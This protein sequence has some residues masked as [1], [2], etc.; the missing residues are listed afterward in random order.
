MSRS[1][2]LGDTIESGPGFKITNLSVTGSTSVT[3]LAASGALTLTS[4]T[5]NGVAY[6]N[7]SKVLTTGSGLTFDGAK[8]SLPTALAIKGA[9]NGNLAKIAMTRTDASYS[10]NNETDLRFYG[11]TTDT[12][13]PANILHS[14]N[15]GGTFVWNN[16]SGSEQMRLTSTGLG[17]GTSS[18]AFK[19]D[20]SGSGVVRGTLT[21]TDAIM[22]G[23][24]SSAPAGVDAFI[25]RPS[26]NTLGFGTASTERMRLNSSGNLGLGVTPSA[27][28]GVYKVLEMQGVSFYSGSPT[29]GAMQQ[30]SFQNGTAHIY[31]TS[32]PASLY[33]QTTGTH[34]WFTAP[35]G[36]AGA[37]ISFTQAM[38][39]RG[40]GELSIGS[41][42]NGV[43]SGFQILNNG[44]IPA[45]RGISTTLDPSGEFDFYINNN[46]NNSK[47]RWINGNNGT[48]LMS[49]TAAGNLSI[50]TTALDVAKIYTVTTAAGLDNYRM[51]DENSAVASGIRA[52]GDAIA[53]RTV[54]TERARIT[55]AGN[56]LVGTTVDSEDRFVANSLSSSVNT[57]LAT[58]R[59]VAAASGL[60]KTSIQL[61][62]GGGNSFGGEISGFLDQ[63]VG[64]GLI[65]STVNDNSSAGASVERARITSA[66][67]LLVGTTTNTASGITIGN[68]GGVGGGV[69]LTGGG[70][71]DATQW[72]GTFGIYPRANV[73]LGLASAV[74]ISFE[75]GST[76]TERARITSAGNFRPG[77]D[78]A[79][80]LGEPS[81]RWSVVY[82]ATG[83]INTSDV[84]AKLDFAPSFGLEFI[85]ALEPVSYRY[86]NG[87]TVIDQVEDGVEDVPAVLDEDGNEVTPA[88]TKPKFKSVERVVEGQRRHHGL[89]AQ[90]VKSVLEAQGL[91]DFAGWVMDDPSDAESGQG[92]RYDQF[93]AP[94]IR[95]V[96]EQQ[97]MIV[98]LQSRL[99]ALEAK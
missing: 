63:G 62:K 52:V 94:L 85:N 23:G 45:R 18:P 81:F 30:N 34:R 24:N 41:D 36:T 87:K 44:K 8:L 43:S 86:K 84:R 47:F 59:S 38:D 64:G 82:A 28:G 2:D 61:I 72:G 37:P 48:Q 76:P 21:A 46:Q 79:Y 91:G 66:G 32:N 77:A 51:A 11:Q 15:T 90:Q 70:R 33:D 97:A 73:G 9:Q 98:E 17:I 55:A 53:F 5:A 16:G 14:M 89:K 7:G 1:R 26:D 57:R 54:N 42:E 13:S 83:T 12:E 68:T 88:T 71:L 35:S 50:G 19:L 4:G 6:L 20:V 69:D 92:L 56:L 39:L 31:K 10:I 49:L 75:T 3:I 29:Y 25:Y 27:W 60:S 40:S 96:Q 99:A 58:Y 74:A 67:N 78:N 93:I 80:S 22:L 95:A 65:F